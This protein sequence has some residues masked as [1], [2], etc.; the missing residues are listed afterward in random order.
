[1]TKLRSSLLQTFMEWKACKLSIHKVANKCSLFSVFMALGLSIHGRMRKKE[2]REGGKEGERKE[3]GSLMVPW[4]RGG[5]S[6]LPY[7]HGFHYHIS[8]AQR[9][10]L[11]L[12][13]SQVGLHFTNG[14]IC[15]STAAMQ[16]VAFQSPLRDPVDEV[17]G[18]D[19]SLLLI[20]QINGAHAAI[21]VAKDPT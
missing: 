16:S 21:I 13:C 4:R 11:S 15:R 3:T 7:H 12:F 5:W 14:C 9:H 6:P 20:G 2:W 8:L 18:N 17:D 19:P 10:I 1:M